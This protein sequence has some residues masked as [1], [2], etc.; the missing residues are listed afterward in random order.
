MASLLVFRVI[1]GISAALIFSSNTP[2][3][4]DNYPR[5]Q[6]GKAL[7]YLVTGVYLGLATG[8]VFGGL[9]TH[10][11]GWRSIFIIAAALETVFFIGSLFAIPKGT[12]KGEP[13]DTGLGR[14]D[15]PGSVMLTLAIVCLMIGFSTFTQYTWA[16]FMIIAAIALL[17]AFIIVELHTES[18]VV[19]VRAFR[20]NKNYAFS[21]FAALLNYSATFGLT[22]LMSTYL[23]TVKGFNAGIAGVILI[24]QPIIMAI[25]SPPMGRMSDRR[26][27][28]MLATI[29][30]LVCAAAILLFCFIDVDTPLLVIILGLLLMGFGV[31]IFSSPNNRAVMSNVEAKDNCVASS[32]L[33]TMRSVGQSSSLAII[34]LVSSLNLGS[35]SFA[36]ASPVDMVHATRICFI[37]FVILSACA[38][39]LSVQ[40]RS[41]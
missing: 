25:V 9:L 3:L 10:A 19:N 18:P 4:L 27:P 7:G 6:G 30:M 14:F 28:Y 20:S 2:I 12:D 13:A 35:Q 33:N 40:R 39:L 34:T 36:G 41:K 16:K 22:Y 29:G 5:E 8:P 26:S 21:N 37:V 11:L 32:L 1:S 15:L 23:Q 24:S 17:V 38:I 31:G